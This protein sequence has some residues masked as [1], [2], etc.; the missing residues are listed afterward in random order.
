MEKK[1]AIKIK[2]ERQFRILM[3]HYRDR[4]FYPGS[5]CELHEL[6]YNSCLAVGYENNFNSIYSEHELNKYTILNFHQFASIVGIE[7][8]PEEIMIDMEPCAK[9]TATVTKD[10]VEFSGHICQL[11][12]YLIEEIY[13]AY[14]SL[15]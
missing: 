1:I 14:K 4:G 8:L 12:A 15:Q 11:S 6:D 2:N 7:L 10:A 13:T 5:N 3:Q 9:E